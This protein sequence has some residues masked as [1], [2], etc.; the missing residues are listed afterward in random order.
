MV[1]RSLLRAAARSNSQMAGT[2]GTYA[3]VIVVEAALVDE[4]LLAEQYADGHYG[5]TTLTG[6]SRW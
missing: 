4:G 5:T 1:S 2:R 6:M 3:G